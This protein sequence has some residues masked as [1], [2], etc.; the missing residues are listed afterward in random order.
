MTS[1][2]ILPVLD[3]EH[4]YRHW[5]SQSRSGMGY[6]LTG[7]V[8]SYDRLTQSQMTLVELY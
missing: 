2:R 3:S 7:D 8:E 4:A 5:Y 1:C 6:I